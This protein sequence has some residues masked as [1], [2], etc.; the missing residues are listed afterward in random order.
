MFIA[1]KILIFFL[2][3]SI[4]IVLKEA[5]LFF[6]GFRNALRGEESHIKYTTARLITLGCAISYIFT[7]I[8]T[9][10]KLF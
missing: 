10:L 6:I 7:I 2:I 5:G 4:L 9:G 3:F 8:L 1:E